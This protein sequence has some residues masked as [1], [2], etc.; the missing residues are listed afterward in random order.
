MRVAIS[1]QNHLVWRL[2]V[3]KVPTMI[4]T[5][6]EAH[7]FAARVVF[8]LIAEFHIPIHINR[9]KVAYG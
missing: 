4:W 1:E 7:T 2:V 6:V 8:Y 3:Q 5:V 9:F